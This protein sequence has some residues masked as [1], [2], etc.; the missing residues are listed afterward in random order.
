MS[1]KE[2]IKTWRKKNLQE[3]NVSID[4]VILRKFTKNYALKLSMQNTDFFA[5]NVMIVTTTMIFANFV[6]KFI[7]VQQ[8]QM[9]MINGLGAILA[10]D[11]YFYLLF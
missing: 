3:K 9:M 4:F 11:G 7:P 2:V 8:I 5:D 10:V 1:K 6:S